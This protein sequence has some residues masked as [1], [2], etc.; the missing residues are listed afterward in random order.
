MLDGPRRKEPQHRGLAG[1]EV[2]ECEVPL[3]PIAGG[4]CGAGL[5]GLQHHRLPVDLPVRRGE[6]RPL[7]GILGRRPSELRGCLRVRGSGL[8]HGL[9]LGEP[10]TNALTVL[11]RMSVKGP[12]L[13][14]PAA[15]ALPDCSA[16]DCP[17]INLDFFATSR[18]VSTRQRWEGDLR[19][20]LAEPRRTSCTTRPSSTKG[21]LRRWPTT[22]PRF[23][24]REDWR[25]GLGRCR[26]LSWRSANLEVTIWQFCIETVLI[27][28]AAHNVLC[29]SLA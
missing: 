17:S 3:L 26:S 7:G 25:V 27:A 23:T 18:Q 21:W 15:R 19:V 8:L 12:L 24:T 22:A 20:H 14:E 16:T 29:S 9:R 1:A 10:S 2:L 28:S 13:A 4:A 6:V 11:Q 5:I